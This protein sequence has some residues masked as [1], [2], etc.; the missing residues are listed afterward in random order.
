MKKI[1]SSFLMIIMIVSLIVANDKIVILHWNDV[2]AHNTPWKP[3]HHNPK[4][5]FVGGYAYL[6]AYLDSLLIVYPQAMKMNAGDDYQGTPVSSISKGLSQIEILNVV[7]PDFFTIGNHEFDYGWKKFAE[8]KKSAEFDI[9]GANV[10]DEKT[11]KPLLK[12]YKILNHNG[13]KIAVLGVTTDDL[14]GL[15]LS[16]NLDGLKIASTI[17]TTKKIV[18]ELKKKNIHL[19]IALT[20][21]GIG[22]DKKLAKAVPEL[23]LIVGGH[24]H[25]YLDE[26]VIIGNTHIVQVASYGRYIGEFKF[27]CDETK[28]TDF[29][30]KL[31]EVISENI[32]PSADVKKVVD[33]WEDKV[34]KE[35]D[36]V[37]GTLKSDWVRRGVESNLGNWLADAMKKEVKTDIAFT[38]N[39]GIRKDLA[40]GDIKVRDI[41]EI[42]P[43]GNT[44]VIFTID[45]KQLLNM[46]E[47]MVKNNEIMQQS[48]LK[49]T[50]K[51]DE[52]KL[53]EV[54]VNGKKIDPNKK[55][56]IVTNNYV[57]DHMKGYFGFIPNNHIETGLIDRN[58]FIKAVKEQKVI[59]S[60]VEGRIVFE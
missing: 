7:N 31:I 27:S 42:A 50:I 13:K 45:G 33:K 26:A 60:K 59:D 16:E 40:A 37:I 43:F 10:L 25:T 58:V 47:Y 56:S 11:E 36:I 48:G 20:H 46:A 28:I 53:L 44:F 35:M 51:K 8:L 52:N 19:I 34:S 41:W 22:E 6:D 32:S 39:G 9:Y 29:D 4:N 49:L 54:L 38:N 14:P 17:E 23:D 2:H 21:I 15:T 57:F 18:E 24:S 30:Y 12:E 55:Y 1:I 3:V 5:H